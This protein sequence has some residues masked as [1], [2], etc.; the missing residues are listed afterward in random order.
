MKTIEKCRANISLSF[1]LTQWDICPRLCFDT[2]TV[3]PF[4][5][6]TLWPQWTRLL[7][8]KDLKTGTIFPSFSYSAWVSGS[9]TKFFSFF[10]EWMNISNYCLPKKWW[11]EWKWPA[12]RKVWSDRS[13][14]EGFQNLFPNLFH[15]NYQCWL[16][17]IVKSCITGLIP[18]HTSMPVGLLAE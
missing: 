10:L 18:W 3:C 13:F 1:P 17:K 11:E 6:I 14:Y 5:Y 15:W 4:V 2:P 9:V 16:F 8:I 12:R 7:D